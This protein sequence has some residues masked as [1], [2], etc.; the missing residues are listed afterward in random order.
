[1]NKAFRR[2]H[3]AISRRILRRM[4]DV[5][6]RRICGQSLVKY[7]PSVYRDDANGVGMT[8]SQSTSYIILSRIFAHVSLTAEDSFLDVGCGKGRVL[9]FLLKEHAPCALSG[10]EISEISGKVAQEWTGRYD[11]V[12]VTLGDAFKLDYNPYTV[13]FLGRPFLPKTF[14]EFIE[15]SIFKTRQPLIT[16]DEL[17]TLVAVG[18][19]EGTLAAREPC[20]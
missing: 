16:E 15:R 9:A 8:G 5:M 17:K 11:K 13:L 19:H 12:D 18:Q 2:I 6:D 20:P 14:L 3:G 7:V 1:M 4:D 10:V